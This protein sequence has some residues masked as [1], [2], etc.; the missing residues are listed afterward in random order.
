[1]RQFKQFI[2]RIAPS[3]VLA[4]VAR[5]HQVQDLVRRTQSM[6]ARTCPICAYHGHFED[7]GRPPR[8]DA[9]CPNCGS[10]ER[11]RL[12]WLWFKGER[13]KLNEPILHFAPE[14]SL[15]RRFREIYR[16]YKTADLHEFADLRLNI[17]RIDLP[18]GSLRT[19]I[20]NHVLEHVDDRASLSEISRVLSSDGQAILSVPIVEGWEKTY[21]DPSIVDP[22]LRELH[23]GLADHV[24][25]YGRD[26]RQ[27][28][29]E[30]GFTRVV[31]VTA[32]GNES[33]EYALVPG[34][35]F[36]ICAKQ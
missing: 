23:F 8:L 24:R 10:L 7:F 17:E 16:D 28:L 13:T 11:H 26:F 35:K 6:A 31:E 36:F 22:R 34:E 4:L 3:P 21:E 9:R 27:R 15:E 33:V 18:D 14:A 1:M 30:A 5:R 20:C 2:K 12:F 29:R 19:I 32:E 25:Y